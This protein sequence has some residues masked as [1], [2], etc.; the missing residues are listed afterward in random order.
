MP[1]FEKQTWYVSW[2]N[3]NCHTDASYVWT[4]GPQLL[5]LGP[6]WQKLVSGWPEAD[7]C[8]RLSPQSLVSSSTMMF[9]DATAL[10]MLWGFLIPLWQTNLET[11][12]PNTAF[13]FLPLIASVMSFV[14][15]KTQRLQHSSCTTV[16]LPSSLWPNGIHCIIVVIQH[17][18]L[19]IHQLVGTPF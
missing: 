17:L 16:I 2:F 19:S 12:S 3:I 11:I 4:V 14:T 7:I 13:S 5:L 8:F 6:G 15:A 18:F 10:L 9:R 1:G